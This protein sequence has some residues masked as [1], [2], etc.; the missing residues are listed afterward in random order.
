MTLDV[1]AADFFKEN[2]GRRFPVV[3]KGVQPDIV[4]DGSVFLK[5]R[6]E[7]GYYA[8]GSLA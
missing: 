2:N 1:V 8:Y 6:T 4:V 5:K 3:R 7:G